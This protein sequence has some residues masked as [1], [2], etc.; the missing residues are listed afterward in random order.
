MELSKVK[1]ARKKGATSAN[2][3]VMIVVLL[4]FLLIYLFYLPDYEK[5]ELFA[6]N[7]SSSN[8]TVLTQEILRLN[9]G[10]ITGL[11]LETYEFS[12]PSVSVH[13]IEEYTTFY[14]SD[15]FFLY[16]NLFDSNEK[17]INFDVEYPLESDL[18]VNLNVLSAK[19]DIKVYLNNKLIYVGKDDF[20][21]DKNLV[22]KHNI[23]KL[24]MMDSGMYLLD[25]NTARLS[26]K[27]FGKV[28][29]SKNSVQKLPIFIGSQPVQFCEKAKLDL[30]LD[31]VDDPKNYLEII[32]NNKTLYSASPNCRKF[33]NFEL[34]C[35]N[36]KHG[37]NVLTYISKDGNY[38][39]SNAMLTIKTQQK[40]SEP[41][42]FD[43]PK[44]VYTKIY[45]YNINLSLRFVEQSNDFIKVNING[46]VR[47]MQAKDNYIIINDFVKPSNNYI[48]ITS[49]KT[50][51]IAEL[52][53]VAQKR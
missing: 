22:K 46:F 32:L 35:S 10:K 42:Y 17:V 19:N 43:I 15:T 14:E 45:L 51:N 34:D 16:A 37:E 33:Y 1:K 40:I 48:I 39:I 26:I 9:V 29:N 23:L 52:K 50:I 21:I 27:I 2:V 25:S 5:A 20:T 24:R 47:E 38:F 7:S 49:E 12:I 30:F 6:L 41:I 13:Y 28:K 53:I 31:C 18:F 44:E 3:V 8:A 36:L 11:P 4:V